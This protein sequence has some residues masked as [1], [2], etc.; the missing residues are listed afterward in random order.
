MDVK[1]TLKAITLELRRELEGRYDA[2]GIWHAGD[3]ERRLGEIGVWRDRPPKNVEELTYRVPEDRQ[4]RSVV[5]AFLQSRA[6]A[7]QS[8]ETAIAEFVRDAAY[9]WANRL[10]ALRCMEARSLIDEV[11]LQKDAYGG[12]SL[13]HNRL[14]KKHPERCAGEDEGLFAVL[15][16]EFERRAVELPL[17]FDPHAPEV[18]LH[19]SLEAIKNCV[20]KLSGT[21]DPKGRAKATDEVFTAADA[22][23]WTYQYWNT[24]EKDRVFEK[25]RTKKGSKIEGAEIIPATCIYTEPYMVKFLVQN[26]LGASWMGMHPHSRLSEKWEYYVRDP[27]RVP[28]SKKAVA[29]ITFLDP[30][31]GSGHFLIEAFELFY[32]MYLEEG[33][34]TDPAQICA[35]ILERNLYGID[36]DGRAAQIA[37][38]ALVMKAKEKAPDFVP[39]RVN[40]VSTD[41][42][43]PAG[44]EHLAAFLTKHPE[45]VP[46]KPALL[47]I[48]EGLAHADE[49]GSLLQIEEPVEEELRAL[50]AR[51]EAS[52][53]PMEQQALWSRFE[54]PVQGKLPIGVASYEAWKEQVFTRVR[55]H[56]DAEARHTDLSAAFFGVAIGKGLSLVNL[57]AR[58]Y[59]VVAANPPYLGKRK[60]GELIRRYLKHYKAGSEDL[61]SSFLQRALELL[62]PGGRLAFV[63]MAGYAYLPP[64]APLRQV[65]LEESS[66]EILAFLGPYAFPEMR[67]HVNALLT[68]ATKE[69][70]RKGDLCVIRAQEESDKPSSLK[71]EELRLRIDRQVFQRLPGC[72]FAYWFD[73]TLL[74][75]YSRHE[76]LVENAIVSLGLSAVDNSR[77][78]RR[79]WEVDTGTNAGTWFLLMKGGQYDRWAGPCYWVTRWDYEGAHWK[80]LFDKKYPYASGN[81]EWKIHDPHIFFK[82]GLCY[83]NASSWGMGAREL[84]EGSLFE[85]TSPGIFS[86]RLPPEACACLLNSR[87]FHLY[88]ALVNPSVH[89]QPGD[90]RDV[91]V[92]VPERDCLAQLVK[93]GALAKTAKDALLSHDLTAIQFKPGSFMIGGIGLEKS[94]RAATSARLRDE[95]LLGWFDGLADY[96]ATRTYLTAS[97]FETLTTLVGLPTGWQATTGANASDLLRES[98]VDSATALDLE[99]IARATGF[100][101]FCGTGKV[102]ASLS[103]D[104]L[105]RQFEEGDSAEAETDVEHHKAETVGESEEEETTIH[106]SLRMFDQTFVER[107]ARRLGVNPLV[108][109]NGIANGVMKEGWK[110]DDQLSDYCCNIVSYCTMDFLGYFGAP[111]QVRASPA[112]EGIIQLSP[113]ATE[114]SLLSI[115]RKRLA[116]DFN[117]YQVEREFQTLVGASLEE[118]LLRDFFNYHVSQF[119][120]RPIAWQIE[121]APL[122]A[123][124][125]LRGRRDPRRNPAFSCLIYCYRLD[126]DLL[127]K[128]RTQYVGPLR[129]SLKTELGSLEKLKE[130]SG[131]QDE[132]RLELEEKLEELKTFDSRLE[133]VIIE[134]FASAALDKIT[135]DEPLDIWTSRDGRAP[136]PGTR[137]ALLAQERRYDPDLNDGFR[138]NIAPL[139]RADLLAADVLA[140]K[141]V[142]KAIADRAEWRADERRWCREGKLPKPGWWPGGKEA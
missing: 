41:I 4:A 54:K 65:L 142:E 84:P 103:P 27:D 127:P 62:S 104:V 138:V 97:G 59:D 36:I 99:K 9:T 115:L 25:V 122:S 77:F 29:D 111:S 139:Q 75:D 95:A 132:R 7:G 66:L 125:K 39:R 56:F 1:G 69:Q 34:L 105:Q 89:L 23:G 78:Y 49:L 11:V 32:A 86:E 94:W 16:H 93:L 47:T 44:K 79:R 98:G 119:K 71:Q 64:F 85:D 83:T 19:P 124:G 58:R 12:R 18:A 63:T 30:A 130:R 51:Y 81:Y 141:D 120:K 116:T 37:A 60:L 5:D 52:G 91:P 22:L 6:E 107:V 74:A 88:A 21:D 13:Q 101:D 123:S 131:D 46:L 31:C 90:V 133:Q 45:D 26:S 24:E 72:A 55:E 92:P 42:R 14:A 76:N 128:L 57:L 73:E 82:R 102:Q 108:V 137:D 20:A 3:L 48:F 17:L 38:L 129:T 35:S 70:P 126:S 10:M 28:V 2:Q 113:T 50:K 68:T 33:V 96:L 67:D 106:A 53:S 140:A 80:F 121:S 134:G 87:A 61:Y 136:T 135:V 112:R 118:W 117:G 100:T 110:N 43:L 114:S 8:R 15:H 40:L 109:G